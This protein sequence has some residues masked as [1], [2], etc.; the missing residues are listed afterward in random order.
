MQ[1]IR[2]ALAAEIAAGQAD[3]SQ[4]ASKIVI[5]VGD[6]VLFPS[7]Q[8]TLFKA[9]DIMGAKIAAALDKEPKSIK[10]IGHTD[11][12]KL[13]SVSR[14]PSNLQLSIERAKAVADVLKRGLTESGRVQVGRA[15]EEPI[16]SN[17]TKEGRAKN[18][19]VD[20]LLEREDF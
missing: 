17:D 6:L 18:R 1:R 20:I 3:A 7:G 8:A 5:R 2:T 12:V 14:F 10:V 13:S 16:A 15:D 19:R 11:N 9:F 4:T